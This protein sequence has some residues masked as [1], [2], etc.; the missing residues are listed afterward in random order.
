MEI[1][2]IGIDYIF[3]REPKRNVE[4]KESLVVKE[5][6]EEE[7]EKERE[8][9][10]ERNKENEEKI[11]QQVEENYVFWKDDN[12]HKSQG[13]ENPTNSSNQNEEFSKVEI[14]CDEF[15]RFIFDTRG[16]QAINSKS[17]SLEEGEY[18]GNLIFS[19]STGAN[20]IME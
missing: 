17:N 8:K 6:H 1:I 3:K 5:T 18:D 19:P 2:D 12:V 11:S 7:F 14:P 20:L 4:E 9:T 13:E 16:N 15:Y 10:K